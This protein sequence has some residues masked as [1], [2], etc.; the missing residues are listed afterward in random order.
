MGADHLATVWGITAVA[1][2]RLPQ[3]REIGW[4]LDA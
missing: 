1:T 2:A 3:D 4:R